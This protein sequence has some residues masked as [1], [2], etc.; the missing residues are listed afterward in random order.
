VGGLKWFSLCN[1]A[2]CNSTNFNK[3]ENN[4]QQ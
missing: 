2:K 1:R 4:C 3:N